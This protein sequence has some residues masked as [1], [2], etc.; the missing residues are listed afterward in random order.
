MTMVLQCLSLLL[1]ALGEIC[2]IISIIGV[3]RFDYVLNRMHATTIAD[4]LG[5]LLIFLG[6]VLHFGFSMTSAK[7]VLVVMFQWITAPVSG[8][9]IARMCYTIGEERVEQHTELT[10]DKEEDE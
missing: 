3:F 5:T 10:F 6:V 2:V 7:L 4:T 1:I 8:H 9:M